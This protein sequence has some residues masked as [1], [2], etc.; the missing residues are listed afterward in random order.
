MGSPVTEA[1]TMRRVVAILT[2][3][4]EMAAAGVDEIGGERYAARAELVAEFVVEAMR[5]GTVA[6]AGADPRAVATAVAAA[7]QE[8][9][10][11]LVACFS[12]AY[13]SLARHHDSGD[14]G[15]SSADVLRRLALAVESNDPA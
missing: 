9:L 11:A 2:Q 5:A 4:T 7:F 12:A 6:P 3:A 14:T 10:G 13:V 15:V 8:R 1:E